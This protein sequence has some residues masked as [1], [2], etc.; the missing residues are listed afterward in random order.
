MQVG[1]ER[2]LSGKRIRFRTNSNNY[3]R[4][5]ELHSEKS[6]DSSGTSKPSLL[7]F[8][9]VEVTRGFLLEHDEERYT[10]RREKVYSFMKIP[11]EV[12]KF[13]AYGFFQCADSFLFVYTFLP[14]RIIL[15]LW[16][17]LSRPIMNCFGWKQTRAKCVLKPAEICDLLKACILVFCSILMLYI[18]TSMMYHLIKSQSVIKLY[19][20]FNMLEVSDRLFSAFGQDTIDALFWTAI[21][22]RDRGREHFGLIPHLLLSIIYFVELKG[23]VF[24]KFDKNNLFQ[25]SCSDVRERFHLFVLLFIVVL[26]T[27]KEYSWKEEQ[28]WILLPDCILVLVSEMFV[29]WIKHAFISRF[30][31][32]QP[33][34][35]KE[36]TISLAYDVA[37]TRQKYA[38]ADHSDWVARR[39]GFIPLPLG[40]VMFRVLVQTVSIEDSQGVILLIIAFLALASFRVLNSLVILGKACDLISQHKL[41]K[42]SSSQ[43]IS[44]A[45]SPTLNSPPSK[46]WR[47][48]PDVVTSLSFNSE[49]SQVTAKPPRSTAG[50]DTFPVSSP[51]RRKKNSKVMDPNLGPAP[52]FANSTVDIIG[53]CLNEEM[54]KEPNENCMKNELETLSRSTPDIQKDIQETQESKEAN[55]M[56]KEF[57]TKRAE[58]EPSIPFLV[59]NE[60]PDTDS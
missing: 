4:L 13:M 51:P 43:N 3:D 30:N 25:A 26:Q 36:Y 18:D 9:K 12:E 41:D 10:K 20:F 44:R 58:S 6:V 31:E 21:E 22:P 55:Q 19:I 28:F 8:L 53:V 32:L 48:C 37:K 27:M 34:I 33:E 45:N 38:F 35:Y 60:E 56:G 39:M 49:G 59:D 50:S 29:D 11:R 2:L 54:L 16:G 24:K 52:L 14:I 7:Q 23:S 57:L 47:D 15:S 40:V 1:P 42:A 46:H 5:E 17:I